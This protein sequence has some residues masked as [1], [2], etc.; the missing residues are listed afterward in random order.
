MQVAFC[1]TVERSLQTV[2]KM[3]MFIKLS[4]A[5]TETPHHVGPHKTILADADRVSIGRNTEDGDRHCPIANLQS[6]G[7]PSF[8]ALSS[9]V[10]ASSSPTMRVPADTFWE[11]GLVMAS[12]NPKCRKSKTSQRRFRATG[13]SQ[14]RGDVEPVSVALP[15]SICCGHCCS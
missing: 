3:P 8:I 7:L 6:R 15:T 14:R 5:R 1:E 11:I 12:S 4:R 10:V 2:W 13:S 9:F